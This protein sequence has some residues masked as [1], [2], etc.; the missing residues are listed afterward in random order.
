[1]ASYP[2]PF[3]SLLRLQRQLEHAR[4]GSMFD[5]GTSSRG[6]YPPINV[7]RDN[8]DYVVVT[9]LAGVQKED[10]DVQVHRNRIRLTGKKSLDYGDDVS[11]HRR[12]RRGGG[13]DRT[14]T[15]PFS[16]DTNAVRAEYRNGILAL[17]LSPPEAEKPR[18]IK[19][20]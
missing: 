15:L 17:R 10:I 9:E 7:F 6:A 19:L 8:G 13:F 3:E 18:S 11:I 20:S 16:I 4:S 1:M 12:E 14:V 5:F 2:S